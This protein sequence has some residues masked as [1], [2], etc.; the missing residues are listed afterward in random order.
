M[1]KPKILYIAT[2]HAI[3]EIDDCLNF[4]R[5]GLDYFSTGWLRT[6]KKV[7]SMPR[8]KC[9]MQNLS[10]KGCRAGIF[11]S[12]KPKTPLGNK[13]KYFTDKTKLYNIWQFTKEFLQNFDLIITSHYPHNIQ[14]QKELI[15]ELKIPTIIKTFGLQNPTWEKIYASFRKDGIYIIRNSPVEQRYVK[16][17]CGADAI[18]R[19]S[20][21]VDEN[22]YGSW[23][24]K[25]KKCITLCS[26]FSHSDGKRRKNLYE[27]V[28]D[29][30]GW[31]IELYG[32]AN[33]KI[34]YWYG[35]LKHEEK[36]KKIKE[37]RCGLIVGNPVSNN[38]YTFC[39]KSLIGMPCIIFNKKMWGSNS[40]EL[41]NIIEHGKNGFLISNPN[42]GAET[43]DMLMKDKWL[44]NRVSKEATKLGESLW[45]R[46]TIS[47][48]WCS[49]LNQIGL[50]C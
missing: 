9:P 39:E 6:S 48:Q 19:G 21:V 15:K 40:S 12:D 7:G 37:Y 46:K 33:E 38:T 26:N 22:D 31:T 35:F 8:M 34:P 41:D 36:I 16:N 45:G 47:K 42:E 29:K 30:C 10:V 5:L 23:K 44:C 11:D 28:L 13:N 1:N 20:A 43:I 50:K 24:G 49:F 3:L 27:N 14:I 17:Y 18:I 4:E 32:A 2:G 25:Q